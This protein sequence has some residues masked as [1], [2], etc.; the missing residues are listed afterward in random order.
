MNNKN[1]RKKKNRG[2]TPPSLGL[3]KR[4]AQ[5]ARKSA[6]CPGALK[7]SPRLTPWVTKRAGGAPGVS[8]HG[9]GEETR[10]KHRQQGTMP[11]WIRKYC[12]LPTLPKEEIRVNRY[13]QCRMRHSKKKINSSL[14][15]T[16]RRSH[17]SGQQLTPRSGSLGGVP[18]P[19]ARV[20]GPARAC[21]TGW[22]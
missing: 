9:C 22:R 17:P 10:S 16:S 1:K 2:D 11:N 14:C 8:L 13:K 20:C 3:C 21:R 15:S 4:P 18:G 5:M 12:L 6:R 19:R 7:P